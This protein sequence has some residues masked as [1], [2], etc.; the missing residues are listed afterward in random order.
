RARSGHI[1]PLSVTYGAVA[2]AWHPA[3]AWYVYGPVTNPEVNGF[4]VSL[5]DER[6]HC[7]PPVCFGPQW[8]N[9]SAD[10]Y[11]FRRTLALVARAPRSVAAGL[12]WRSGH[13]AAPR[14]L[15]GVG[16][17]PTEPGDGAAPSRRTRRAVVLYR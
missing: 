7:R 2:G 9:L 5:C 14:E 10:A 11:Q 13:H 6:R 16:P 3:G 17:H 8:R 1:V 15:P 4:R 12:G